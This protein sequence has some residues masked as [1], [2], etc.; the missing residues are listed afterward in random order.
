VSKPLPQRPRILIVDDVPENLHALVNIL[1][2][3]YVINAAT[4][5]EKALE[6][7]RRSP[8][9]DLILLDIKMPGMDGY[10]VLDH[11]KKDPLTA[12]I[13]VIFVS[14][15]DDFVDVARGLDLGV[16]DYITKPIDPNLLHLRLRIQLQLRHSLL[17]TRAQGLPHPFNP[18][19]PS[20]ILI[21][22]DIPEGAHQLV[23]ALKDD[24][25]LQVATNGAKALA[26]V[27]SD[28]PPDLILLDIVMPGMDGYEVCRRIKALPQGR[29]IPVIFVSVADAVDE[30]IKGFDAGASDYVTKPYDIEEVR[31]RVRTHLELSHLRNYLEN[32][33][34]QR[35]IQLR[36]N[37][38]KYRT[39]ADFTY[40]WEYWVAPDEHFVYISPSCE[41]LTGYST[42]E[43]MADS[44]LLRKITH[45][46][47]RVRMDSHFSM[48]PHSTSTSCN[49]EFRAITKSGDTRWIEHRC[50]PVIR[51]DGTYLGRRASNRDITERKSTD[52]KLREERDRS[53][54]YLEMADVIIVVVN[55]EGRI[56][57]I[58]RKGCE[59]LGLPENELIGKS[60][61][62]FCAPAAR[63]LWANSFRRLIND[64]DTSNVTL[65]YE[66]IA[67]DG[68]LRQ[69]EWRRA[70]LFDQQNQTIG[71]LGSGRDVTLE[72]QS[73]KTL[74]QQ[75]AALEIAVQKRTADLKTSE[76]RTRAIVTTM[77]DSVVQINASGII[78]SVNHATCA[79]FGYTEP[80]LVGHNV[81][82]LM[83]E[84]LASAHDGH[85]ARYVHTRQPHVVG[86]RREVQARHK[87]GS[88]FPIELA[89][90]EM[91]DEFGITFIGVIRNLTDQKSVEQMLRQAME[92]AEVA[93]QAKSSFLANMSHEIRTPLNA[94]LGLTQI[95][96]RDYDGKV[97]DIFKRLGDS[98]N[99]LLSVVNDILDF[100]KIEAGKLKVEK[101]PFALLPV[102]ENVRSFV[103]ARA[104]EKGLK[105]SVLLPDAFSNWVDGDALRLTQILSNLLSNAVKFT[106]KGQVT[107]QVERQNNAVYFTVI[108]S[109]IGMSEEQ[110]QRLFQPFE[111]ADSSTTRNYGGSGLGLFISHSL[112][113]MMGGHITVSSRLGEGSRFTV[114]L[115]LPEV[116][117]P[118]RTQENTEHA[119]KGHGPRLAGLSILA[120]DDMEIN[121]MILEDLLTHEGAH[122]VFAE[123]G[124]RVLDLLDE[125]GVRA[126]DVVLIDV[127]MPV[128]D[129]FEAT[130]RIKT[131][132]PAL[133]VIA[134]T[135]HALSEEKEKTFAAGMVDHIVK[136]VNIDALVNAIL[137]HVKRT[138]KKTPP[139]PPPPAA[140]SST[141]AAN[142]PDSDAIDL[143]I[144]VRR[145]G[146]D[147]AKL[148]RFT[149]RFIESANVTLREMLAALDRKDI[150]E[151]NRQGHKLKSAALTV[152]AMQFGKLCHDLEHFRNPRDMDK[153]GAILGDLSVLLEKITRH[154]KT[155]QLEAG[156][157]T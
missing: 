73:Q 154:V 2:D 20:R 7:A 50:Q 24:H 109:G 36:S 14:A 16:V 67:A 21:V 87:D 142:L 137:K 35:T 28:N 152:G 76:A 65:E 146:S 34:K 95:G 127:Q 118:H 82:M 70:V 40:D 4:S 18:D 37:E 105:L 32:L 74:A 22:D 9:P 55:L 38:E 106:E 45:P 80:E 11:L 100:S 72:R 49:I 98:G 43:F 139:P 123:D 119:Q 151:L 58:N 48:I 140:Q 90:N 108:D 117:P 41:R 144:L 15:L 92:T 61:V 25:H 57:L 141:P 27:Q 138:D 42:A 62:D 23:Q 79:L 99:H 94:I 148:S 156:G 130:R 52:Q 115:P 54:L 149:S 150:A 93:A 59:V 47:D 33:V 39:V 83:P 97:H 5:G 51:E 84:P 112:A 12:D 19:Y 77:L 103:A 86:S 153:A 155:L 89:V 102:I 111:Q 69:I 66:V 157:I 64:G 71:S 53:R 114:C 121:R 147:P 78:L 143:S 113:H 129:G 110:T 128:M 145:I 46:D 116:N 96:M 3:D 126:F 75:Q 6:T 131:I 63:D 133:P 107:L 17:N 81:S 88:L 136:P 44:S 60:W 31:V 135:A 56:E 26:I 134:L 120:A 13:P 68:S 124:Q 29:S 125:K 10:A 101:R 30:K 104:D 1:R 8:H 132:A 122:V 91:V 85:L